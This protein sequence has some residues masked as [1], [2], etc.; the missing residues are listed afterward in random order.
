MKKM[1]LRKDDEGA[2]E[3]TLLLHLHVFE[4]R[5]HKAKKAEEANCEID[6]MRMRKYCSVFSL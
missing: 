1:Q 4:S 6:T 5:N 2:S 3:S